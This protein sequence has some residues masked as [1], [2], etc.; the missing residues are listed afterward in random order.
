LGEV[1]REM[2][3]D[4]ERVD[5]IGNITIDIIA[6]H[7]DDAGKVVE[8]LEKELEGRELYFAIFLMGSWNIFATLLTEPAETIAKA[9]SFA[10]ELEKRIKKVK[11]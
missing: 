6:K 4:E 2:G 10:R 11:K 9:I 1:W 7:G 8:E 5:E 3:V